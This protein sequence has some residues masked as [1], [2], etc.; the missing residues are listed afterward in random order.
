M[1]VRV[2]PNLTIIYLS[3]MVWVLCFQNEQ[4]VLPDLSKHEFHV[5]LTDPTCFS[6]NHICIVTFLEVA[7]GQSATP[8]RDFRKD[9]GVC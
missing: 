2:F 9:Q 1:E 6:S 7:D 4:P 5:Y 3:F 8:L